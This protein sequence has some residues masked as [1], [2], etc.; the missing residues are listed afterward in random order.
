M[1]H[2]AK[3]PW[4][5]PSR[6]TCA[7]CFCVHL[8]HA[9]KVFVKFLIYVVATQIFFIFTPIPGVS[10]SNFD[11]RIFFKWVG[12]KPPTSNAPQIFISP[13]RESFRGFPQGLVVPPPPSSKKPEPKN[14]FPG[15]WAKWKPYGYHPSWQSLGV[16]KI[17][18][19]RF[20]PRWNRFNPS[21]TNGEGWMDENLIFCWSI[22]CCIFFAS[23]TC[24]GCLLFKGWMFFDGMG[25]LKDPRG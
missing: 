5:P 10:W 6:S 20:G 1:F 8:R 9:A 22:F 11:L 19:P 12:E 3:L 17:S 21:L 24:L 7:T 13:F 15:G 16:Q 23:L 14:N 4:T 18:S 25:V 2:H